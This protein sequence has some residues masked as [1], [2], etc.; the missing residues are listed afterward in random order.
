MSGKHRCEDGSGG[1]ERDESRV[2]TRNWAEELV[3]GIEQLI[4][5]KVA[6]AVQMITDPMSCAP[7]GVERARDALAAQV[8]ARIT[9]RRKATT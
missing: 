7:T 4:D 1:D 9:L 2:S 5:A 6:E 8:L 3:E